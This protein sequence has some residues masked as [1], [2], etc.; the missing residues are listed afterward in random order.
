MKSKL[1][2]GIL[3]AVILLGQGLAFAESTGTDDV[4]A[5][6][7]DVVAVADPATGD[8]VVEEAVVAEEVAPGV[9]PVTDAAA[10]AKEEVKM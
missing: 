3:V 9:V 8:A 4:V 6:A 10:V 2:I 7:E 5:V 1:V